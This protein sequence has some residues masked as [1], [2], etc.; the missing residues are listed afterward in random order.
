MRVVLIILICFLAL[1]CRSDRRYAR[2]TALLRAEIL[3][4]EDKYYLLKSQ[5]DVAVSELNAFRG[6]P[7][8]YQNPGSAPGKSAV[9]PEDELDFDALEIDEGIIPEQAFRHGPSG[10]HGPRQA[11]FE[12]PAVPRR[13]ELTRQRSGNHLFT[14]PSIG[15][16]RQHDIARQQPITEILINRI[17]TRGR[18]IDGQPGDEGMDILVQPRSAQGDVEF[19]SGELT[20]S[21]IDPAE[22]PERQRIGFWRFVPGETKLFF[23]S[24]DMGNEGILLHLPWDQQTPAN[25]QLTAHV[26]FVTPDGRTIKTST[27]L[28]ITPPPTSYSADDPLIA[29]W[30]LSDS[31]WISEKAGTKPVRTAIKK[32][33][34]RP[35]R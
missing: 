6:A 14:S 9:E 28:R 20:V 11:G 27:N 31:R 24:D 33:R 23:A 32:P 18:D 3:D 10:G 8:E 26:R 1:G 22:P 15:N 12:N 13:D 2:E 5:H 34:W 16:P 19:Q 7:V 29:Q 17:V 25:E 35:V 4:L 21:L 30:T